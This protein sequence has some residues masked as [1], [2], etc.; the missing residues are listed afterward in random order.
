MGTLKNERLE[1]EENSLN[2]V[3]TSLKEKAKQIIWQLQGYFQFKNENPNI[4]QKG[5]KLLSELEGI[6]KEL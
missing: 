5:I 3:T 2:I 6:L 1:L 4:A